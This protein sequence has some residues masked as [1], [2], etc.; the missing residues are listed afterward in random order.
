MSVF[1]LVEK[2]TPTKTKFT[3]HF[4]FTLPNLLLTPQLKNSTQILNQTTPKVPNTSK[5]IGDIIH[6]SLVGR[7]LIYD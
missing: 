4:T 3:L 5:R 6:L 1:E 2:K 7:P